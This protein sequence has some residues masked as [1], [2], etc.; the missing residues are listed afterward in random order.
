M[1]DVV[2][3]GD[4]CVPLK[5]LKSRRKATRQQAMAALCAL[6]EPLV[7]ANARSYRQHVL[8]AELGDLEQVARVGLLEACQTYEWNKGAFPTHVMWSIRN[9]LSK[10]VETLGNPVRAPAWIVRRLP[11]LRR[12]IVLMGH[13][14]LREPT[15]DEL[16]MRMKMPLTAIEAMLA[17]DDGPHQ[18]SNDISGTS[19][20]IQAQRMVNGRVLKT[21]LHD[22]NWRFAGGS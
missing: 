9:A 7:K 6:F 4:W 20:L 17:Y 19:G 12:F 1:A 15:R 5:A 11:K 14:L 22:A 8:G 18:L 3:T 16:A 10:Y 21:R 2:Y 13:E